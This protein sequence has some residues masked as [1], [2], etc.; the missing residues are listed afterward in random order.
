MNATEIAN[1]LKHFFI[2]E[3]GYSATPKTHKELTEK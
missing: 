2:A 3:K 1:K